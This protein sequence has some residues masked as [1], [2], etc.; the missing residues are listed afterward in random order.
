[1]WQKGEEGEGGELEKRY[2]L[3]AKPMSKVAL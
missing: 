2:S 3:I 1:M